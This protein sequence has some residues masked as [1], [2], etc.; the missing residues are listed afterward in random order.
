MP[1]RPFRD[2]PKNLIEWSRY[3]ASVEV[4]PSEGTVTNVVISDREPLSVMGR[5]ADFSGPPADI[6]ATTN[7]VYLGRRDNLL[8]FQQVKNTEVSMDRTAAE[9]AAVVTPVNSWHA[10]G[11][12][13]RYSSFADWIKVLSEGVEGHMWSDMTTAEMATAPGDIVIYVHGWRS[14][15]ATEPMENI[16]RLQ[17]RAYIFANGELLLDG[18]GNV[19]GAALHY[20]TKFPTLTNVRA[21][22][23]TLGFA[24]GTTAYNGTAYGADGD[25]VWTSVVAED[26]EQLGWAI[27]GRDD[28]SVTAATSANPIVL[29]VAGHGLTSGDVLDLDEFEGDFYPLNG[30]RLAI[31]VLTADTF[32]IATDGSAFAAYGGGATVRKS[33]AC[34]TLINCKTKGSTGSGDWNGNGQFLYHVAGLKQYVRYGGMFEGGSGASST[35]GY[36]CSSVEIFGG[37]H[38]KVGRGP[39][40]GFNTH[41][42]RVFG[43]A[44][45][46]IE[47]N[48][49]SADTTDGSGETVGLGVLIGN[50][51]NR[52]ARAVRTTSSQI[53][54]GH[55]LGFECTQASAHM[56]AAGDAR[57]VLM[58][59]N[60][61][62]RP[63]DPTNVAF[64][65]TENS[66]ATLGVN[67]TDSISRIGYSGPLSGT[68]SIRRL[69]QDGQV[70][71]VTA[72]TDV[73]GT[74]RVLYVDTTAGAVD[75][76][77][78]AKADA[79]EY[80]RELWLVHVGGGNT[81]TLTF[82]GSGAD[83]ETINGT[84]G[85]AVFSSQSY[86]AIHLLELT[87]GLWVCTQS[88]NFLQ[89]AS[90]T[91]NPGSLANTGTPITQDVTVTGAVIGDFV[92]V[93]FSQ[94]LLGCDLVAEVTAA[95][96]VRVSLI[97]AS[98][99]AHDVSNGTLRVLV[100]RKQG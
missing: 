77:L 20:E 42:F 81:C 89:S 88:L 3:F 45:S 35:D 14:V 70:R 66:Q 11:D 10:E 78:P 41:L 99:S 22:R 68:S 40:I 28:V 75:I 16:L 90:V 80:G 4:T 69:V 62:L 82:E 33:T 46:D 79:Q 26:C 53:I 73:R 74:D 96:T 100:W 36:K 7:G 92:D 18:G 61:V 30:Q 47:D 23:S 38:H 9:I 48:A 58:D 52:A 34:V 94:D 60:M 27:R 91:W 8:A 63:S 95:D 51:V 1:I 87:P 71:N 6:E 5:A 64:G 98:G 55:N 57:E 13:R 83:G 43:T 44:S 29:T 59:G 50:V 84:T 24:G 2:I 32:S 37:W 76:D 39:T 15:T 85:L 31:T 12:N 72:D 93:S 54:V 65:T 19:T 97:N 86:R 21:Y 49:V 56:V 17:G 67:H 25:A